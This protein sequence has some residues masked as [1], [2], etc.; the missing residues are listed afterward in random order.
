MTTWNHYGLRTCRYLLSQHTSGW[1]FQFKHANF[2]LINRCVPCHPRQRSFLCSMF[3]GCNHLYN[4]FRSVQSDQSSAVCIGVYESSMRF[5]ITSVK[6]SELGVKIIISF[7]AQIFDLRL[8]APA[9]ANFF[10]TGAACS[11]MSFHSWVQPCNYI[12]KAD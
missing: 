12:S 5:T 4:R 9:W 6:C 8:C 1:C 7:V 11:C 2:D 10:R 3:S